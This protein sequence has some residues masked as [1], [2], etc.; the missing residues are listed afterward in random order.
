MK[1]YRHELLLDLGA[2][3]EIFT[4]N[5]LA[6]TFTLDGFFGGSVESLK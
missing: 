3:Q 4:S 6:S 5:E 1:F 2:F